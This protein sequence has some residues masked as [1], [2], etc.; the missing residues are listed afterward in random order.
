MYLME[1]SEWRVRAIKS[2]EVAPC[3][4]QSCTDV[5]ITVLGGR[6][7]VSLEMRRLPSAITQQYAK[8]I[9]FQLIDR[10]MD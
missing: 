6:S 3:H 7:Q 1:N 2:V 4:K 5:E 8:R 9:L 10:G